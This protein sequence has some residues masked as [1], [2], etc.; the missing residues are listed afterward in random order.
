MS[1]ITSASS[2]QKS[3]S[4]ID[5]NPL[6]TVKS[7]SV[8]G[9]A[10]IGVDYQI[11]G[12]CSIYSTSAKVVI[13]I[14][15]VTSETCDP[16]LLKSIMDSRNR[17]GDKLMLGHT[18]LTTSPDLPKNVMMKLCGS[19]GRKMYTYPLVADVDYTERNETTGL[20]LREAR[21]ARTYLSF[22]RKELAFF[23]FKNAKN[24]DELFLGLQETFPRVKAADAKMIEEAKRGALKRLSE[25]KS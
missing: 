9:R 15:K 22:V 13:V 5:N 21:S 7:I 1:A 6:V 24:R 16:D 3:L 10:R 19:D 17:N 20:S 18:K 14:K 11:T 2:G 8:I 23:P 4:L 25:K 12:N